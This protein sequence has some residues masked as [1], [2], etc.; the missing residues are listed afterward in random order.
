[1]LLA[2][3]HSGTPLDQL[4]RYTAL[5]MDTMRAAYDKV[6]LYT[7]GRPG[8][9]LQHVVDAFAAQSAN[10]HSKP[11]GVVFGLVGLYLRVEKQL[12]GRQMRAREART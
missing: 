1:M 3:C 2:Q 12:S 6:Y 11:I 7:V 4:F 10:E 9:T 8:F 5:D